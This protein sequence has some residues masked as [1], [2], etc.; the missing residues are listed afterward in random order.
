MR[1]MIAVYNETIAR[2]PGVAEIDMER[3]ER[4]MGKVGDTAQGALKP[5]LEDTAEATGR[6]GLS[7]A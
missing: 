4:A 6:P 5:A 1:G 2:L 7:Y 3:I